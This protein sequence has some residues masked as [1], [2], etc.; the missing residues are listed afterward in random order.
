MKNIRYEARGW[1][2]FSE[3]DKYNEGCDPGTTTGCSGS[4]LFSAETLPELIKK[5][6][7][8]CGARDNCDVLLNSCEE[9]G[10][11]DIQV[12]ETDDGQTA[13]SGQIEQWKRGEI[14]LWASCY[15][16]QIELV[17]SE[18]VDLL[19]EEC[20]KGRGYCRG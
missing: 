19:A 1:S 2:K 11:V 15:T 10:R 20:L 5:C 9:L 8:F 18:E 6:A 3:V 16:F 12:M 14:R 13:W 4:D 7:E 17:A